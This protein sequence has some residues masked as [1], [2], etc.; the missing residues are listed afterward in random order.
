MQK[1]GYISYK[2]SIS[3]IYVLFVE[4]IYFLPKNISTLI[5]TTISEE[6]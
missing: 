6:N 2:G 3:A 1:I 5:E 4:N